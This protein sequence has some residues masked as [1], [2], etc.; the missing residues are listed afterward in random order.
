M[1]DQ[2]S[3]S[4]RNPN[5]HSIFTAS[6]EFVTKSALWPIQAMVCV[7]SHLGREGDVFFGTFCGLF[8][9]FPTSSTHCAH[10]HTHTNIHKML[11][12]NASHL[13]IINNM[14]MAWQFVLSSTVA[15]DINVIKF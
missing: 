2:G 14:Y 5:F 6:R 9:Y 3:A 4:Q 11:S 15:D 8:N 1:M 10:T 12:Q 13:S 7:V